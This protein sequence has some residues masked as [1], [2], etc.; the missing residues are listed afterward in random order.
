[1]TAPGLARRSSRAGWLFPHQ[2]RDRQN[3]EQLEYVKRGSLAMVELIASREPGPRSRVGFQ[4]LEQPCCYLLAARGRWM[5]AILAVIGADVAEAVAIRFGP[6]GPDVRSPRAPRSANRSFGRIVVQL[7]LARD[8]VRDQ[9]F[10]R[11]STFI[12]VRLGVE[13]ARRIAGIRSTG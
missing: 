4:E 2:C 3:H 13:R 12:G 1:R 11:E 7:G 6:V 10:D 9:P 8:L 5:C